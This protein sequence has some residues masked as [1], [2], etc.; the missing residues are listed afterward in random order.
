MT[1]RESLVMHLNDGLGMHLNKTQSCLV[2]GQRISLLHPSGPAASPG[3]SSEAGT[4]LVQALVRCRAGVVE[5][6]FALHPLCLV[7]LPRSSAKERKAGFVLGSA[8]CCCSL[9][10]PVEQRI[11]PGW[12]L[13][14]SWH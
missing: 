3:Q 13:F 14:Q 9:L 1:R 6:V 12:T 5:A 8:S 4:G 10:L 11:L 2:T 7:A